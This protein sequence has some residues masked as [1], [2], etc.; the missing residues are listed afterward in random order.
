MRVKMINNILIIGGICF[1]LGGGHL[2]RI[3]EELED[4]IINR[5]NLYD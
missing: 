2:Q 3:T 4:K 5:I 1:K